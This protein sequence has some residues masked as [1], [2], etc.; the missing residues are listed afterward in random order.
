MSGFIIFLTQVESRNSFLRKWEGKNWDKIK[1]LC[2]CSFINKPQTKG[3]DKLTNSI[4]L[5]QCEAIGQ[6]KNESKI[7]W[8][9]VQN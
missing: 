6:I 4:R 1:T 3:M 2:K 7:Y 8:E 5:V 9:K